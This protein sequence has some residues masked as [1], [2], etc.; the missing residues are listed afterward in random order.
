MRLYTDRFRPLHE[1]AEGAA[2]FVCI[3]Y[4][5]IDMTEK[6]IDEME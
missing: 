1:P 2:I 5:C 4:C 3:S 6:R